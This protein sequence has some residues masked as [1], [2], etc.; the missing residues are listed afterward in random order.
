MKC[1]PVVAYKQRLDSLFSQA[2]QV[3]AFA[4]DPELLSHWAKYLCVLVSGF[5][6]V[7]LCEIYAE[8]AEGRTDR[9]ISKFVRRR[10]ESVNNPRIRRIL[11]VTSWFSEDWRKQLEASLQDWH[12]TA[13]DSIMEHRHRIAHG[14][15][16]NISYH[17][18]A[19]Y[20]RYA[21][22]V[23]ELIEQQCGI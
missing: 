18:I 3:Q 16:S 13:V 15:V 7:A 23:V 20:Y 12:V 17:D 19:N 5:L 1:A 6:E 21:V 22:E 2:K 8:Y 10:L 9:Q 14:R 11:E 4:A